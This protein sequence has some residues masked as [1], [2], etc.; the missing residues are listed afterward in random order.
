MLKSLDPFI[1]KV[2]MNPLKKANEM[3]SELSLDMTNITP[4]SPGDYELYKKFFVASPE[5]YGNAWTYI[6]QGMY[7][8]G[9]YGIG[10]KYYDGENLISLCFYPKLHHEDVIPFYIVRPMGKDY[11]DIIIKLADIV[12]TKFGTRTYVKKIFKGDYDTL[13]SKGFSDVKLSPWQNDVPSEDDT[14]P[15]RILDVN[16][17]I[18]LARSLGRT[19]QL[20]RSLRNYLKTKNDNIYSFKSIFE[21]KEDSRELVAK[22]FKQREYLISRPEDY[23]NIIDFHGPD[24]IYTQTIIYKEDDPIGMYIVEHQ[25]K[26]LASLYATITDREVDNYLTD[27]LMFDLLLKL[28]AMGVKYLNLGGSEFKSLDEFKLKFKPT[29][30]RKMYWATFI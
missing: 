10:Y 17:T 28:E 23:H 9:D 27:F 21:N 8:I 5:T 12:K 7:G 20:N 24:D 22:F 29:I 2:F 25:S 15:E 18:E 1:N 11:I 14:Y 30:E 16:K 19:R 26:E 13:I 6:I 3:M 4:I